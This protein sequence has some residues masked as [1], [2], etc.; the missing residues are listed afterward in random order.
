VPVLPEN[1]HRITTLMEVLDYTAPDI[2]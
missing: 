2:P 1:V